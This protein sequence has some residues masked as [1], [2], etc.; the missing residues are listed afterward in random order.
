MYSPKFVTFF[1]LFEEL[2]E[3]PAMRLMLDISSRTNGSLVSI[4]NV[5][6]V[7]RGNHTLA[8]R[9]LGALEEVGVCSAVG[10]AHCPHCEELLDLRASRLDEDLS[11]PACEELVALAE[12]P[13]Y[14]VLAGVDLMAHRLQLEQSVYELDARS[15]AAIWEQQGRI[16]YLNADLVSSERVQRGHSPEYN[17][18]LEI[19]NRWVWTAALSPVSGNYLILGEIGDALKV[20]FKTVEQAYSTAM[21]FLKLLQANHAGVNDQPWFSDE[22]GSTPRFTITIGVIPLPSRDGTPCNVNKLLKRTLDNSWDINEELVT[23]LHRISAFASPKDP[24]IRAEPWRVS[25]LMN[26]DALE[27]V[28]ARN[29]AGEFSEPLC[30]VEFTKHGDMPARDHVADVLYY[31]DRVRALTCSEIKAGR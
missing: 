27:E 19:V 4:A 17:D 9:A 20:A 1:R 26:V 7:L 16:A 31:D 2:P 14:K 11:C 21:R 15:L 13:A 23:R 3:E 22:A 28:R 5:A 6:T 12:L 18:F 29:L 30:E 10:V 25:L 24:G 8:A